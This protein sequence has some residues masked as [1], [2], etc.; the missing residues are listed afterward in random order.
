[1]T[2][3]PRAASS[4]ARPG[5]SGARAICARCGR[6][7]SR[8]G[9]ETLERARRARVLRHAA[10]STSPT[11]LYAQDRLDEVRELVREPRAMR[12]A[13]RPRQLRLRSTRSRAACSRATRIAPT[14]RERGS[15]MPLELAETTD[16]AFDPG[17][18]PRLSR[19][20]ARARRGRAEEAAARSG[21]MRSRSS[22]RRETSPWLRGSASASRA[23]ERRAG[24]IAVAGRC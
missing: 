15:L 19:R 11:C 4:M 20:D 18:G 22:T 3:A 9:I 16:Y 21:T 8:E 6:G 14:R 7:R 24:L 1:M 13:R 23:L 17:G 2:S 5:S 10:A 12:P